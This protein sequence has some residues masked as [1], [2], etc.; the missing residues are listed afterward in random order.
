[1]V[2]IVAFLAVQLAIPISRLGA[3]ESARRFGWQMFSTAR[4]TPA[5][6][7]NTESGVVEIEL[8]EYM[9]GARGDVDIV[10]LLP[11]HLCNVVSGA[12]RVSWDSGGHE[13]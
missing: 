7:V 11:P 8:D 10:A 5:F 2:V 3:H 13:C 9:A 4:E 1:M 6:V 12:V